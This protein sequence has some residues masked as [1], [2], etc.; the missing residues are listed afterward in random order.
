M[1]KYLCGSI[2]IQNGVKY[3]G[4]LS[5]LLFKSILEYVIKI[6]KKN[7]DGCKSTAISKLLVFFEDLPLLTE[8]MGITNKPR[9]ASGES[10]QKLVQK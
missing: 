6:R 1:D 7:Y 8:N 9:E 4:A 10:S 3:G 5:S 2:P